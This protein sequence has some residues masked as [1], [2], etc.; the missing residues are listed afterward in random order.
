[1]DSRKLEEFKQNC[2][3]S[4]DGNKYETKKKINFERG[5]FSNSCFKNI[6]FRHDADFNS[7]NLATRIFLGVF[8]YHSKMQSW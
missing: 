4:T 2:I 5:D 6:T 7:T 1:M 3:E 8:L